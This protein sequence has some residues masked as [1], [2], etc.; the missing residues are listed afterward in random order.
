MRIETR[1]RRPKT[2]LSGVQGARTAP[3]D[4]ATLEKNREAFAANLSI[5]FTTRLHLDRFPAAV[6][7]FGNIRPRGRA[8]CL[9]TTIG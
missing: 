9:S 4:A 2:V 3:T 7:Q 1:D 6:E 8:S 5:P